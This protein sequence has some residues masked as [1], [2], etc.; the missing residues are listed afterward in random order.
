MCVLRA[1]IAALASC[2]RSRLKTKKAADIAD[3]ADWKRVEVEVGRLS[4]G[5]CSGSEQSLKGHTS[6]VARRTYAGGTC[7]YFFSCFLQSFGIFI[8]LICNRTTACVREKK[9]VTRLNSPESDERLPGLQLIHLSR[10][11]VKKESAPPQSLSG[12]RLPSLCDIPPRVPPS[13]PLPSSPGGRFEGVSLASI[14]VIF[15]NTASS[16]FEAHFHRL[17]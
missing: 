1:R 7:R 6:R 11:G 9:K 17:E 15:Q 14:S 12:A 3:R 5:D 4:V 16:G 8:L 13:F 10:S 2:L